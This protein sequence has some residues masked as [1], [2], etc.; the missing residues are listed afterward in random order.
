MLLNLKLQ[1]GMPQSDLYILKKIIL[2]QK[3]HCEV[4]III[5]TN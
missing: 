4:T 5:V 2:S 3:R 1:V